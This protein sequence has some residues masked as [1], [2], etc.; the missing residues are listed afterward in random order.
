MTSVLPVAKQTIV[1]ANRFDATLVYDE[2][3]AVGDIAGK[4]FNPLKCRAAKDITVLLYENET[5]TCLSI[6]VKMQ[7]S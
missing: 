6:K 3:I 7:R 5:Q 2:V 1:T 4:R